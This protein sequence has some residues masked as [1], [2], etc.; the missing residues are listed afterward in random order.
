M[1]ASEM[2][3]MLLRLKTIRTQKGKRMHQS[4]LDQKSFPPRSLRCQSNRESFWQP[5]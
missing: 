4:R 1:Q 2:Q 5:T 3:D